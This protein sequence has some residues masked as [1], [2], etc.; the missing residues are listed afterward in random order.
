MRELQ[1]E[2]AWAR[3]SLKGL[4]PSPLEGILSTPACGTFNL[5][6][7]GFVIVSKETDWSKIELTE[8]KLKSCSQKD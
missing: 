7:Q 6:E 2:G 1:E 3:F 8:K 4:P 5:S